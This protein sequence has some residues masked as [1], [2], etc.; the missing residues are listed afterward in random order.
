MLVDVGTPSTLPPQDSIR[1]ADGSHRIHAGREL[2]IGGF[3]VIGIA[4]CAIVLIAVPRPDVGIQA[5]RYNVTGC[6]VTATFALV[7]RG[8]ADGYVTVSLWAGGTLVASQDYVVPAQ[9]RTPGQMSGGLPGCS[10][11]AFDLTLQYV[12]SPG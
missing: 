2:G 8:S 7:N 5:A 10:G 4:L 9:G 12:P 11:A 1:H 3:I 6:T